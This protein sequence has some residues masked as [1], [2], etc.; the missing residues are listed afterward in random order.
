MVVHL[1]FKSGTHR[2]DGNDCMVYVDKTGKVV[3]YVEGV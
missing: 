3:D 1:W 2:Q